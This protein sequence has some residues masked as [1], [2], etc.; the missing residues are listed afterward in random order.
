M[1][2]FTMAKKKKKKEPSKKK[3][4]HW[5]EILGLVFII[6]SILSIV[7]QPMGFIG[8]I[9]ASFAMFLIGTGYQILLL[10]MLLL[11]FYLIYKREWPDFFTIRLIGC[12][13]FSIGLIALSHLGYVKENANDILVVFTDTIDNLLANF[14][15]IINGS[16][17]TLKGAGI[18]GATFSTLF[19]KLFALEGTYIVTIVLMILGIIFMTGIDFIQIILKPF[20]KK[21]KKKLSL[22][23]TG[24]I[25]NDSSVLKDALTQIENKEENKIKIH[26]I[27]EITHVKEESAKDSNSQ[28]HNANVTSIGPIDP[29]PEVTIH[30]NT[31]YNYKLPSP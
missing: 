26:S 1:R 11:G 13:I 31:N 14:S 15:N 19:F 25:V 23:D 6:V 12:Y 3:F 9:G 30:D 7:P 18:I 20:K 10:V 4:E 2:C 16:M 24:V 8:Q 29:L 21:K 17:L 28:L 5:L 27:D 22:E